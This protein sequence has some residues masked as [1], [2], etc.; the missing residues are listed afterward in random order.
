[1]S[2]SLLAGV[3]AAILFA[4]SY[5]F[6]S[7]ATIAEVYA[8]HLLLVAL[9]LFL[10]LRW[11]SEPT[12]R[13][14]CAFLAVFGLAFG[15]HLSTILL[16]PAYTV[17]VLASAP[18]GWRSLLSRR[19]VLAALG[20]AALGALQYLWNFSSLWRE[21]VPPAGLGDALRTFWFDVTKSDWRETMVLEVPT[22]VASERLR[23][24]AFDLMQQF[25]WVPP[26]LAAAGVVVLAREQLAP[27]RP[28]PADVR[29]HDW[30]R[31]RLQ[32][33]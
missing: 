21:V 14:L 30:F 31:I 3:A 25:G 10:V 29:G 32:R 8:L 1:M 17:F 5:T 16:L 26:L 6:W 28:P 11:S 12:F 19:F 27:C 22:A 33:R 15:N 24:Y 23:M 7:Q 20:F 18:G 2:G 9:T 13:R 4:G